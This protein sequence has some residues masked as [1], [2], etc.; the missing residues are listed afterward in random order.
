MGQEHPQVLITALADATEVAL[1]AGG[2]LLWSQAKPG[3]EV[4]H[5]GEVSDG[6]A[7]G[8]GQPGSG[9]QADAGCH[10]SA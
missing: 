4:T 3:G 10:S 8:G 5:V 6:A 9:E 2:Y 1:A 7:G